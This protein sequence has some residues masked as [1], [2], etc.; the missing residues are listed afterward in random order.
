MTKEKGFNKHVWKIMM[1]VSVIFINWILFVI[2]RG[3]EILQRVFELADTSQLPQDIEE[4]ALDFLDMTMPE[5]LWE[6]IWI[7]IFGL[8]I[9]FG[10]RK[11]Q[12]YAW[13]LNISWGILH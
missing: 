3:S 1:F 5:P 4:N 10:L 7:G 9:A 2:S 13:T 11:K 8:Y 6:E 12:K